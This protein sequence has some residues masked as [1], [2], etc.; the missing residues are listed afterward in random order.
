MCQDLLKVAQFKHVFVLYG[1]LKFKHGVNILTLIFIVQMNLVTLDIIKF[2]LTDR[3]N[4]GY[5]LYCSYWEKNPVGRWKPVC[6]WE[7]RETGGCE[8]DPINS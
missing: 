7:H 1:C 8:V 2:Y 6:N 4:A 3:R 5:S